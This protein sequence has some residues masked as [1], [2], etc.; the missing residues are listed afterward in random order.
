MQLYYISGS[1]RARKQVST[2]PVWSLEGPKFV[3]IV[4]SMGKKVAGSSTSLHFS[5]F[6]VKFVELEF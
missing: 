6:E 1:W 5:R 2:C 4:N 3:S